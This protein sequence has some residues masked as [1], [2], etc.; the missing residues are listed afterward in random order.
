M[1]I[2]IYLYPFI[3]VIL[4]TRNSSLVFN[5]GDDMKK[6]TKWTCTL[7]AILGLSL[8]GGLSISAASVN[9]EEAKA[10]AIEH[11]GVSASDVDYIRVKEDWDWGR[12]VYEIEFYAGTM[13]YDYDVAKDSGA[14]LKAD[15]EYHGRRGGKRAQNA[16]YALSYDDAAQKALSRVDG[17]TM[18]NLRMK[19]DHSHGRPTYEGEIH[20]NGYEYEFEIDAETGDFLEW[21]SEKD[22]F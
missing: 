8:A 4:S 6:A 20:Y 12:T 17:A 9:A 11:A 14:I 15:S 2:D 16:N 5:G 22:W 10:I 18:D 21:K 1:Y 7:A 13:E 19:R 3:S